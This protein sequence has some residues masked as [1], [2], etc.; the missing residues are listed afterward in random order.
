[1]SNAAP[2]TSGS[3][4]R[5]RSWARDID[6]AGHSS[7]VSAH[8]AAW[9]PIH[10]VVG[11]YLAMGGEIDLADLI[12]LDRCR[13]VVPR[14]EPDDSL[15]LHDFVEDELVLHRY[16]FLEPPE[17]SVPVDIDVVD[18]VLVPG[19]AFDL[20]GNRLG[21]GGG[22]YD[23]LLADLPAGVVRVGVTTEDAVV[24]ALPVDRHD[25]PVDWIVTEAGIR[26]V[27][28]D[29]SDSTLTVVEAAAE[30]G[31]AAAMVRFP[32]GTKTSQDAARAVGAPL[33]SIAKTLVFLVD[34][35][36]VL[37]ICSGDHRVDEAKLAAAFGAKAAA[38]AP[39][40]RV[41]A[42]TGY[43]AGGTPAVGHPGPLP[44]VA[45]VSLARYRW[46][47]SAGGTPDT[48]YPVS[49]ARLV[50]ASGARWVDVSERG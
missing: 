1:M 20:R 22:M 32:E 50:A 21:R 5:W 39:L 31:I 48:V 14:A 9:A 27:S 33:G 35:R 41:R 28:R 37:V 4:A 11:V 6:Q 12:G 26:S 43:V 16:G 23:R 13:I 42:A 49:L 47:W 19:L 2:R 38:P 7:R 29:L 15:T 46:V 40:E 34:D 25:E 3:K 44:V 18:V 36:P 17:T 45:D 10:G 8:L 30:R 24:D